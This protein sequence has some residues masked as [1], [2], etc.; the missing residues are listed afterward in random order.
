MAET[1]QRP[2]RRPRS[3][4]PAFAPLQTRWSDNDQY[5]HINNPVYNAFFDVVVNN[6]LMA[7]CGLKPKGGAW[8]GIVVDTG[9]SF[10][11]PASYP[12]PLEAGLGVAATTTSSV[13]YEIGIFRPGE[14]MALA[15]GHFVQVYVDADTMRPIPLP[16]ELV[17]GLT[18]ICFA[19][20]P[21]Q[22]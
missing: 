13:R 1:R 16:A 10:F 19:Q 2:S 4:F 17:T 11:A 14:D 20:R 9:V 6:H 3:D 15:Q 7:H 22:G 12:E 21:G 8:R 5:G 18:A